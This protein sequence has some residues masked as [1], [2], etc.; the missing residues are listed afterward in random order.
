M[1]AAR[2]SRTPVLLATAACALVAAL[3]VGAGTAGAHDDVGEMTV[4]SSVQAGPGT[5]R[6]E[7]GLVYENDGHLAEDATVTATLTGP[8]GA[9]AGPVTLDRVD[10]SSSLYA[11]EVPVPST[12]TWAAQISSTGPTATATAAIEVTDDAP[13]AGGPGDDPDETASTMLEA[14]E[15]EQVFTTQSSEDAAPA[16]GAEDEGGSSATPWIVLAVVV[17]V[18]VG[19]GA[20]VWSRRGAGDA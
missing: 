9:T 19:G 4:T 14:D 5:V 16:D 13:A 15:D 20:L 7:V 8:D 11:A 3:A 17:V 18:L 12:G 2:R 10:E 1:S 6:L